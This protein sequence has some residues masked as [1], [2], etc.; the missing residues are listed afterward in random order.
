MDVYRTEEEQVA[1]IQRW[2]RDNHKAVIGAVLLAVATFGGWKWYEQT[3]LENA[4]TAAG[5][6]EG[7]MKAAQEIVAG[8]P[9]AA[10][11]VARMQ[12]A[13]DT[14][15]ADHAGSV[16]A[17]YGAMLLA[18]NAVEVDDYPGA[19]KYLRAALAID[20]HEATRVVIEDRLARVLSAQGKHD[21]AVALLAGDVPETLLAGREEVRGDVLLAKGDRAG[22]RAAYEKAKAALPKD[23]SGGFLAMKLDYV[24][25]Q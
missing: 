2:W 21:D 10:D 15:L 18:G 3:R 9:A 6:Y 5:L 16:Y 20:S 14:L 24:A 13:G 8:G 7:M 25:G 1:A 11:A 22:A 19:E 4:Y 17:Q 12:K 23:A